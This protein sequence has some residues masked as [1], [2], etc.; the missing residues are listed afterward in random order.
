MDDNRRQELLEYSAAQM[1]ISVNWDNEARSPE[2]LKA[3]EKVILATR[4]RG[5]S[6]YAC[7][8][9]LLALYSSVEYSLPLRYLHDL[10]HNNHAAVIKVIA[11]L[12]RAN[13]K[14]IDQILPE[15]QSDFDRM[16]GIQVQGVCYG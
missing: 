6:A 8:C 5:S 2:F 14:P 9:V 12:T 4:G 15:Y 11:V 16:L 3:L 13:P 1:A 10:D 7:K